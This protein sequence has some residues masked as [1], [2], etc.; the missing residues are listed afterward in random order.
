MLSCFGSLVQAAWYG[1]LDMA[2]ALVN[3]GSPVLLRDYEG[4]TAYQRSLAS[5]NVKLQQYLCQLEVARQQ[6]QAE[7]SAD[8]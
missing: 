5:A 7:E 8:L 2:V 4:L 1:Y 6:S 3:A